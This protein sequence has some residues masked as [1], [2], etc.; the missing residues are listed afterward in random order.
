MC[1][2]FGCSVCPNFGSFGSVFTYFDGFECP[3]A[4]CALILEAPGA[5]IWRL[6]VP[7]FGGSVCSY[8]R[9][10]G[11][12][13]FG[14]FSS[15]CLYFD[16][17]APGALILT[18]WLQVPLFWRLRLV[19]KY[20]DLNIISIP[21]IIFMCITVYLSCAVVRLYRYTLFYAVARCCVICEV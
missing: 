7:L 3:F 5:F 2:Y 20:K 10:S 9:G 6:R 15:G 17:L 19:A 11:C 12:L 1:H 18:A 14:G 8:Y 16:S 21:Q 4:S 13:Y